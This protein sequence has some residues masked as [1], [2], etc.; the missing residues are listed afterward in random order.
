LFVLIAAAVSMF[1]Y[2]GAL[3][4]PATVQARSADAFVESLGVNTH[5]GNGIF[6]GGNAY[7]DRRIDAKL[8]ALGIRHIPRSQL[9][10]GRRRLRRQHQCDL[11]HPREPHPRRDDA[12]AGGSRDAAQGPSGVRS[13]RRFERAGVRGNRSY[14]GFTD[15]SSAKPVP[16]RDA[17][18]SE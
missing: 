8:G 5:Y 17:R 6:T 15:N 4:Q 16:P 13:D 1:W 2:G 11:R 7:A 12:L 18:V 3:R 14:N 10:R 9:Q